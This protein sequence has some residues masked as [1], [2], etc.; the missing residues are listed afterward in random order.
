MFVHVVNFWL[1]PGLSEADIKKFEE[2]VQSLKVIESLVMFNVGKPA[3]TDRP[4][5]D[6]SYSYCELT[7]FNDEAGHDVYQKHPVHLAFVENCKH[8]WDKVLIYDSETI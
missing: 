5:I 3:S 2:G 6:R 1:K 7:V 4:V 8:L